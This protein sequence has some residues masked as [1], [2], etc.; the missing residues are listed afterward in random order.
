MSRL[1][2]ILGSTSSINGAQDM[3]TVPKTRKRF[4]LKM[5]FQKLGWGQSQQRPASTTCERC[6]RRRISRRCHNTSSRTHL[7]RNTATLVT[8]KCQLTDRSLTALHNRTSFSL[9]VGQWQ[10]HRTCAWDPQH[11]PITFQ[12]WRPHPRS[13]IDSHL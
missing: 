3:L 13:T 6:D 12:Q 1:P 8:F 11:C 2:C 10:T 4:P 9:A 7:L 5:L